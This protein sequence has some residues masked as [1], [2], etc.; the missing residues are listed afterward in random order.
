MKRAGQ[1]VSF[2]FPQTDL[3]EEKLRPALL[4]GKLPGSHDDWL[5]CMISS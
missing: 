4:L 5:L 1:I 3:E 2:R